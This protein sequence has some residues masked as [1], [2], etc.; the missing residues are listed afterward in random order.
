M[1]SPR[2]VVVTGLG[3][4][5]PV[6]LNLK[7][8]WENIKKGQSG[9]AK[10]EGFDLPGPDL[11]EFKAQIAAQVKG[12]NPED[13]FNTKELKKLDVV[14]QYGLIATDEAVKDSGFEVTE[15]NAHRIGI[16]VSSGIGGITTIENIR[17][18]LDNKGT[19]VS[20]FCIPACLINMIS[21]HASIKYGLKGP[22]LAIVTA[23]STGTHNIGNA[24]R[25]IAYGDADIMIAGG[26]EKASTA[27]G[28]AGFAAARALSTRNDDPEHASRPWDKDRDGFV[29]G[30]GAGAIVIEEYEHAKR[31]G[32][33]IYA[34]LI[35]YGVSG[36]AYHMTAPD[37]AGTFLCMDNA[38]KDAE[39]DPSELDYINA[40]GTST[41]IGDLNE[42]QTIEKMMGSDANKVAVS[43]TKS[44]IGHLLGAAGAVEAIFTILSIR[45]Q[46]A[47]PTINLLEPGEGCNLD[48]VPGQARDMEI[49]IAMSNSFG[50]GGTNG[51][52]IFKKV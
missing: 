25:L 39:I 24:A 15:E 12:Y 42:S 41:P 23:C 32:A 34:E 27:V 5:S 4:I 49:N 45:D 7:D 1:K 37:S 52:L 8:S 21:G 16:S 47:P 11:S 44:M 26:A 30:D 35:G 43:S 29:L 22:N 33:K 19:K 14:L 38:L 36:D 46:V 13:Y 18:Q 9:V 31:R 28:M 20:P 10:L 3:M 51:A 40:H 50:F 2:R 48:Y 17:Q 6:G